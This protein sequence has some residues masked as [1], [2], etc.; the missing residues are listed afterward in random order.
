MYLFSLNFINVQKEAFEKKI[1][2]FYKLQNKLLLKRLFL[3][4]FSFSCRMNAA[5]A[6]FILAARNYAD[7]SAAVREIFNY[8]SLLYENSLK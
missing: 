2:F 1:T 5:E 8:F 7:R 3:C 4:I 6:C